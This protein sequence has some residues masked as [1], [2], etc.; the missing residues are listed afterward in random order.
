[1]KRVRLEAKWR[2]RREL[3]IGGDGEAP[4]DTAHVGGLNSLCVRSGDPSRSII[5]AAQLTNRIDPP[6]NHRIC[7]F[8]RENTPF[9]FIELYSLFYN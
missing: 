5:I 3:L 9:Y 4:A 8:F 7:F 6:A 2:Q 1:M